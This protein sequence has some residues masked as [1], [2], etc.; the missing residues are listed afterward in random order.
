MKTVAVTAEFNPFH[1][2]HKYL[3]EKIREEYGKDTAII[4]VMSGC[5]VQRGEVAIADPYFRAKTALLG[6]YDLILELPFPFSVSAAETFSRASVDIIVSLGCVNA[7]AFG[8][9]GG[10]LRALQSAAALLSDEKTA[11]RLRVLRETED[12]KRRGT[13][14]LIRQ[15]IRESDPAVFGNG[16]GPNDLL[17]IGYLRALNASSSEIEPFVLKRVGGRYESPCPDHSDFIGA[18]ALRSLLNTAKYT[19]FDRYIPAET[20][21]LWKEAIGEKTVPA[22]F[23]HR[24]SDAV[25]AHLIASDSISLTN[26]TGLDGGL[27]SRLLDAAQNA[28]SLDD[29]IA[30]SS[31]RSYSD[32]QIRRAILAAWL[33][34]T[35]PGPDERPLYTRLFGFSD[36]GQELLRTIKRDSSLPILTKTAD[37]VALQKNARNQAERSLFA[38]RYFGLALPSPRPASDAYRRSPCHIAGKR[39]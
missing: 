37:W 10:N 22:S 12:G 38:D 17:A 13:P 6:G 7:V 5:F 35:S 34:F 1:N 9:E 14:D 28:V 15:I 27:V 21:F 20:H 23:S 39:D 18:T 11:E 2:G 19:E 24:L 33:G 32:S 36:R 3:A 16:V 26:R 4:A 8:S 29:L 30:R 31:C 25:L